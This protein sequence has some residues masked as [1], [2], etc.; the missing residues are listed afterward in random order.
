MLVCRGNSCKQSFKLPNKMALSLSALIVLGA[1][2]ATDMPPPLSS[3]PQPFTCPDTL[4]WCRDTF[5]DAQVI[6]IV[7]MT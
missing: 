5:A 6:K 2:G 1:L 7:V 4:C 3:D